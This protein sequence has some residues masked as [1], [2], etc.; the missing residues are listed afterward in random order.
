VR[1][2]LIGRTTARTVAEPVG[3][4]LLVRETPAFAPPALPRAA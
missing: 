3:E 1:A 4:L 2:D